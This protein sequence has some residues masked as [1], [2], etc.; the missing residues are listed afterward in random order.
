MPKQFKV[1]EPTI[2]EVKER[3]F[4]RYM[5]EELLLARKLTR[6][7][8]KNHLTGF[9]QL[10]DKIRLNTLDD[11]IEKAMNELRKEFFLED[12]EN[13]NSFD[14]RAGQNITQIAKSVN[15]H[16]FKK[17]KKDYNRIVGVDPIES[18]QGVKFVLDSFVKQ[19]VKKIKTIHEDYFSEV[20]RIVLDGLKAGKL[21]GTISEEI[22]ARY[23]V[24]QAQAVRIA[25]T[26]TGK[27]Y[28][29]LDAA[30][31]QTNGVETYIWHTHI[32]GRESTDHKRKDGNVYRYDSPPYDEDFKQNVHPADRPNCR[33]WA[34]PN[35]KEALE[36]VA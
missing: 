32:D 25:R 8:V 12:D 19:N 34:E 13:G 36:K 28:T 30:T 22:E 31:A 21:A 18:S 11:D 10:F 15:R 16:Q 27:L 20:E 29:Q 23:S 14:E 4:L 1:K 33:C 3:E 5:L 2:I 6:K 7:F 35:Y 26:E 24:T 17:F 9:K